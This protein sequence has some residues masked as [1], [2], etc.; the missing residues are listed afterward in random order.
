MRITKALTAAFMGATAA[1][2]AT[3]AQAE[4]ISAA[5]PKA[6]FLIA[7]ANGFNPEMTTK[8][9]ENPSFRITVNGTKSLVLFMNCDDDGANCKTV[10][11]YAGF[12]VT[13]PISL[14]H[15]NNWNRDKRFAR[16]YVDLEL[17]PVLEMDLDLDFNGLPSEN[18]AEAFTLWRSLLSEYESFVRNNGEMD[19]DDADADAAEASATED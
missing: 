7:K 1:M 16:A 11:F 15:I 9:D 19:G 18:V 8:K 13:E 14:D 3:P 17:D 2:A 12:S 10:Q 6:V 5:N 4:L